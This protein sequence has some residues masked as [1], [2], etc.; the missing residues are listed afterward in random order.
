MDG[1]DG[2]ELCFGVTLEDFRVA[3]AVDHDRP[4]TAWG[5]RRRGLCGYQPGQLGASGSAATKS[6][7]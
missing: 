4:G 3:V 6:R 5:H 7:E 2:I 1:F